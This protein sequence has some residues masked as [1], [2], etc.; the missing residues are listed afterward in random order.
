[1]LI[2]LFKAGFSFVVGR[3]TGKHQHRQAQNPT[4]WICSVAVNSCGNATTVALVDAVNLAKSILL[5][6]VMDRSLYWLMVHVGF[7]AAG[8]AHSG[9]GVL[10]MWERR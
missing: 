1:M 5:P 6:V 2:Q 4:L 8:C 7:I 9:N 10:V 3:R